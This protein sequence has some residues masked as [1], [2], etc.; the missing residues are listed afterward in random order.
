MFAR[1]TSL[2]VLQRPAVQQSATAVFFA[3]RNVTAAATKAVPDDVKN[4]RPYEEIPGPKPLP[5]F[6]NAFRFIPGIGDLHRLREV[7][8]MKELNKRYGDI[9]KISGIPGKSDIVIL[10]DADEIEKVF[11][12]EGPWPIRD[13][14]PSAGHYR[15]VTRK[16]IFQ[17]VGGLAVT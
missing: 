6:G 11:R 7:A 12:N 5:V 3:K 8:F 10:Y 1:I 17:G 15:L 14:V 16:D 4:A 13:V 9:I 2:Q